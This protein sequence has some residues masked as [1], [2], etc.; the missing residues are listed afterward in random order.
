VANITETCV[1]ENEMQL[2]TKVQVAPNNGDD[3]QLL[4]GA[5]PDLEERTDLETLST[6]GGMAARK[7][8]KR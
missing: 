5:L 4:D 8:I 3:T 7:R 1:P 6:D 2:I